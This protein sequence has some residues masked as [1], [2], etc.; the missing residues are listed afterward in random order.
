METMVEQI[1]ALGT[2]QARSEFDAMCQVFFK[3]FLHRLLRRCQE[4]EEEEGI[5]KTNENKGKP[6][7][8]WRCQRQAGA[9]KALRRAV[10]SLACLLRR[11]REIRRR[12]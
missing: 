11:S 6:V 1:F 10:W 12:Q 7:S 3:R 5:V 8:S 2:D 9:T 4:K